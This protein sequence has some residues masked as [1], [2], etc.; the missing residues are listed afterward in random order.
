M[1]KYTLINSDGAAVELARLLNGTARARPTAVVTIAA[2]RSDP[3]VDVDDVARELD[4]LVDV[5]LIATGPHTWTFSNAM[6]EGT[7]VYGGAGR[8]YPI[9][10]DW[11]QDLNK[12]PLRFAW[13]VAEGRRT[14][15][16]LIDDGLDM[17]AA[18]G[19]LGSAAPSSSR[20]RREGVV[21][22]ADNERAWVDFGGGGLDM[23]VVPPQ[24][25]E[26][27][28]PIERILQRGMV[29]TGVL[30]VESRWFDIRES[31]LDPK[32]ALAEY[33]IGEVVPARITEVSEDAAIA[34]L[35]PAFGVKLGRADVTPDDSD[36]RT[37]LT[38]GEV[39]AARVLAI[40]PWW[41]TLLDVDE[42]P[43]A[44]A[45]IYVGGRLGCFLQSRQ[46]QRSTRSRI[47]PPSWSLGSRS[48]SPL[49]RSLSPPPWPRRL[50]R[51]SPQ[52]TCHVIKAEACA[53]R[54][55]G[56]V[57]RGVGVHRTGRGGRPEPLTE[58]RRAPSKDQGT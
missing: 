26:P 25:A 23:G 24:L 37:L 41:L 8:V 4:Q 54:T 46:K 31:R 3:Y 39:V 48:R 6:R 34:H 40:A 32:E 5:Y 19:L 50:R 53:H 33:E 22:R 36:L 38:P 18:A 12:S 2:G 14:T 52:R 17:A 47:G 29:V 15:Q 42:E 16:R 49:L 10:H 7:Q 56:S 9:G 30:E 13:G 28:L 44:A 20:V 35:L 1:A 27:D 45:S 58:G 51:R 43:V 55:F 11:V 57:S 21:R